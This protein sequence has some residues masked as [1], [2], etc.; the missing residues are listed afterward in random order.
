MK[1]LCPSH[2]YYPSFQFCTGVLTCQSGCVLYTLDEHVKER[3]FVMP[4]DLGAKESCQ[5]GGNLSTNAGG[6][7]VLRYGSLHA[8]VLGIE[9]VSYLPTANKDNLEM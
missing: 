2:Y 3:G 1:K 7:R 5:I 6:L 4:L 9:A 8:T